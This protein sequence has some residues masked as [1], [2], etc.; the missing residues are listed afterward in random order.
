MES[1]ENE[2]YKHA[3]LIKSDLKSIVNT[4][5]P[6]I[7]NEAEKVTK[8]F[9]LKSRAYWIKAFYKKLNPVSTLYELEYGVFWHALDNWEG[10]KKQLGPDRQL[11]YEEAVLS[12]AERSELIRKKRHNFAPGYEHPY[13]ILLE[14]YDEQKISE[15]AVSKTKLT[16]IVDHA[17][18]E[19]AYDN[20]P[21]KSLTAMNLELFDSY[22]PIIDF[23]TALKSYRKPLE[24]GDWVTHNYIKEFKRQKSGMS[25][26]E[27]EALAAPIIEK[28]IY[29][30]I[31]Y[32]IEPWLYRPNDDS[33]EVSLADD[34]SLSITDKK[35]K[36]IYPEMSLSYQ[37]KPY[38]QY[39]KSAPAQDRIRHLASYLASNAKNG[40]DDLRKPY[41]MAFNKIM[42]YLRFD[43][44]Q[45]KDEFILNN[46]VD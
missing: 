33:S 28:I 3:G 39:M 1:S 41:A 43:N 7:Q 37:L 35:I 15:K 12:Q 31:T 34:G 16:D 40:E 6:S 42:K 17:F 44:R 13:I 24:A 8:D 30:K 4:A 25:K 46:P 14:L 23:R 20:S 38:T 22:I 2:T 19:I 21:G 5:W 45:K 32:E 36:N 11:A 10:I 27:A 9:S 18:W 26:E 29:D